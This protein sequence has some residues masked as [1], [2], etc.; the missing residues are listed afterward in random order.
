MSV[1]SVDDGYAGFVDALEQL[2]KARVSEVVDATPLAGRNGDLGSPS[3]FGE[4]S[5]QVVDRSGLEDERQRLVGDQNLTS[6]AS[7]RIQAQNDVMAA[8]EKA[9]F[10]ARQSRVSRM[11]HA[12]GRDSSS[13]GDRGYIAR[14]L[15]RFPLS[16]DL[17]N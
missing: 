10:L 12:V 4:E 9:L 15:R 7:M 16:Y 8:A 6:G 5:R 13:V 17:G 1:T 3:L 2:S 14:A 11:I